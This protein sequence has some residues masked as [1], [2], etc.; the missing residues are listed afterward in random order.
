MLEVAGWALDTVFIC[1]YM[2][3]CVF[4]H[5]DDRLWVCGLDMMPILSREL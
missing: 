3:D 4:I 5:L 2:R 1:M